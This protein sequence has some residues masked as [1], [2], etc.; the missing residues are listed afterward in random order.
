MHCG[1]K[2]ST[3]VPLS[4]KET[5]GWTKRRVTLLKVICPL[6]L[7]KGCRLLLMNAVLLVKKTPEVVTVTGPVIVKLSRAML[8]DELPKPERSV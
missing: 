1:G 7:R 5:W 6:E 4:E 3:K 2:Q 8:P